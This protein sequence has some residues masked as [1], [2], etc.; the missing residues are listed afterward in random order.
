MV[1]NG[2]RGNAREAIRRATQSMLGR[3]RRRSTHGSARRRVGAAGTCSRC[4][5]R[6]SASSARSHQRFPASEA[7][8]QLLDAAV[9]ERVAPEFL[10]VR[11]RN[12]DERLVSARWRNARRNT[13]AWA[14]PRA[15]VRRPRRSRTS[16]RRRHAVC[17][18][19]FPSPRCRRMHQR[20]HR[21]SAVIEV[22]AA[23][24]VNCPA[25]SAPLRTRTAACHAG[26]RCAP[27]RSLPWQWR[28]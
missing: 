9:N 16:C 20:A 13:G 4:R 17:T 12:L 28:T 8:N 22:R 5:A 6:E 27:F 11:R 24:M 26:S 10:V 18:A 23:Q 15:P 14:H 3:D 25:V 19:P 1:R 21:P 7:R 2:P